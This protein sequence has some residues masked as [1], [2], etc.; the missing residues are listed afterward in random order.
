MADRS[1]FAGK[2]L[3]SFPAISLALAAG[4]LLGDLFLSEPASAMLSTHAKASRANHSSAVRAAVGNRGRLSKKQATAGRSSKR[5]RAQAKSSSKRGSR[6]V[7]RRA[8][9]AERLSR[10]GRGKRGRAVVHAAPKAIP[11]QLYLEKLNQLTLKPG[12][13]Y[14][15]CHGALN[16]NVVDVDMKNAE[17]KV[18]PYLASQTF[19]GLKTV[20]QHAKESGALV[21]V[22]A[23][24]FKKD[25]TPLGTIKVDGEWVSGSLFN[26]VAMGIDDDG[27]LK[28][29]RVNLHG[30]LQTSNPKVSSLW[31]NNMN[32]PRRHG[33]RLIVYTRRWGANVTLPYEGVL[34][35]VSNR[36]EVTDIQNRSINIPYGGYVMT[37]LKDSELANLQRGDF[38]DLNW[39]TDPNDW[40]QVEHAVS[41]GP[42]LI[43]D[44]KLFVGLQ[45]EHFKTGW[46][47]AKITR[48]TACG[49][50]AD[51]HLILATVEGPHNM[52]DLA[53]FMQEMGCVEAMNLDGGGSTTMVVNGKTVTRN[54][55]GSQRKVAA[56]ITVL[57]PDAAKRLVHNPDLYY[58]PS[59]DLSEFYQGPDVLSHVP[60]MSGVLQARMEEQ[61]TALLTLSKRK[62]WLGMDGSLMPP[63]SINGTNKVQPE[64]SSSAHE[65]SGKTM[66]KDQ[67]REALDSAAVAPAKPAPQGAEARVP[68][69]AKAKNA[70]PVQPK[71]LSKTDAEHGRS[72]TSKILNPFRFGAPRHRS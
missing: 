60:M 12:V 67:A 20:E 61:D 43:K 8:A 44:G 66:A 23:N 7:S 65:I 52:W 10:R 58:R 64:I 5:G 3:L 40:D 36:G 69:S 45:G 55:P 48:R 29:A 54:A 26:R 49:V 18:R 38:V 33:A 71:E 14:K 6:I 70:Q 50:T 37:D 21:A 24:Y 9:R 17:V 22:N 56:T 19:D 30:I 57:E 41:G 34:V 63:S 15:F 51:K 46:T 59:G 68:K 42:T 4:L 39:Y 27:D 72:W 35:A 28:F 1:S 47:S 53:K 32:Q 31:V 25:G 2:K 11:P 16:V 13:V 62:G